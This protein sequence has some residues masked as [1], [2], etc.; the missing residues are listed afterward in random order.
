MGFAKDG[1]VIQ[2]E[3][4]LIEGVKAEGNIEDWLLKLEKEMQRSV[5]AVCS[6]GA[7]DC[8]SVPLREFV[9][10]YQSQ[11]ALAGI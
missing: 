11:V 4:A 5:R 7:K 1:K 3:I 10:K 6:S 2:E 9:A 8:F